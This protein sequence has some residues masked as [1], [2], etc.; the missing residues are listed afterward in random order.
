MNAPLLTRPVA[1]RAA[2]AQGDAARIAAYVAGHSGGTPFH[3]LIWS[4]AVAKGCGQA[5]RYLVAERGDG[6]IA[7]VLPLTLVRSRLFGCALV[8][9]GFGVDGGVLADDADVSRTLADAAWRIAGQEGATSLELRGG[10]S[11][12][13]A[14]HTDTATYLGFVAPLA[15]DD[16]AQLA[17]I[18]RKQRAEVRK[19]FDTGLTITTG[20]APADRAAHY[21]VYA[22]SVRNLGTPV[23]PR[24]L[25]AAVLDA[26]GDAADILTV[27]HD[28]R[29]VASVLSLYWRGTVYPY[30]GGGN[31]AARPLR[32]NDAMYFALMNHAR[33]KSCTRF[34][35]GRSKAGTGAAA[36]KRNWG[37]SGEPL[38]Y[39]VRTADGAAPRTVNP[40]DPRYARKIAAWK[41]LPLPIA[42]LVGPYLSRGLG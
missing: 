42:N 4:L 8:S 36:F 33:A 26:F 39:H 2:D 35:F 37:F 19:S 10:D 5:N 7:G 3:L 41:R 22:E 18:P 20:T 23:F 12:S 25:F 1:I 6:Q 13:D 16:A 34:D 17:A 38:A 11:P 29:P 15:A 9:A 40:L 28:G 30:W 14:F 32:A 21:A 31:A 27:R 24:S